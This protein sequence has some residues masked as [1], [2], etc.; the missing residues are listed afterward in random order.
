VTDSGMRQRA[1][2]CGAAMRA[3]DGIGNAVHFIQHYLGDA[4]AGEGRPAA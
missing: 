3:E 1:K 4:G 2:A